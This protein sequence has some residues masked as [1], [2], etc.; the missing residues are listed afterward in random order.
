M[1][2]GAV[3]L[4]KSMSAAGAAAMLSQTVPPRGSVR[5]TM[6]SGEDATLASPTALVARTTTTYSAPCSRSSAP[7]STCRRNKKEEKEKRG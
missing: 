6:A 7:T 1:V 4:K 2:S 3:A 5:S